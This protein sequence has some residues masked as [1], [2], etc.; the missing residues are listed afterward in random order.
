MSILND[1]K[2][3]GDVN[4]HEIGLTV[5]RSPVYANHMPVVPDPDRHYAFIDQG[6]QRF[7][8]SLLP[9]TGSWE[10]AGT[11]RRAAELNQPP[12]ALASTYHPNGTL[13]QSASYLAVDQE[14]VIVSVTKQAQDGGGDM[15]LRAYETAGLDSRACISIRL[16]HVDRIIEAHF[17]P[18]EIKT[19]RVPSDPALPIVET[20]LLEWV[21]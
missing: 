1:G 16:P 5:L 19:W 20:N 12:I 2:Y 21:E 11:V 15:I 6:I 18:C 7:T 10:K 3:S 9:H 13:P 4:L 8:Y 14:N 17:G